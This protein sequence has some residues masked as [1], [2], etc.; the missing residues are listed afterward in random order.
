LQLGRPANSVCKSL[1]RIRQALWNCVNEELVAK[2][3][4]GIIAV[5][6]NLSKEDDT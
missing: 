5:R 3:G 1:G 6:R 2:G 4:K